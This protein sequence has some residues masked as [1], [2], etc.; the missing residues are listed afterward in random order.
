MG[1]CSLAELTSLGTVNVLEQEGQVKE[2][3]AGLKKQGDIILV[4]QPS[5]DPNDPLVKL[6]YTHRRS[7]VLN[8]IELAVM[9]TRSNT[10]HPVPHLTHCVHLIPTARRKH[11]HSLALVRTTVY[12]DRTAH[13]I[14]SPR[15]RCRRLHLC[16]ISKSMGKEASLPV[17]NARYHY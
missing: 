17:R 3:V 13:R 12:P 11:N 9:E 4:P 15:R 8:I 1:L 2:N 10:V 5:D 6:S 14:P 7:K 16:C